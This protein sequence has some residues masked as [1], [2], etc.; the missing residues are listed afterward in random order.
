MISCHTQYCPDD[1]RFYT[2]A[3]ASTPPIE[4]INSE[5][6]SH[7]LSIH[8]CCICL[9]SSSDMYWETLHADVPANF[10]SPASICYKALSVSSCRIILSL[11]DFDVSEPIRE[12][13]NPELQ[14]LQ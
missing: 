10:A 14:V 7:I 5:A 13:K 11:T 2:A 9:R 8:G 4:N 3:S 12:G 1:N 6:W